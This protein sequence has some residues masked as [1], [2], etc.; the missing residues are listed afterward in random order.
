[1]HGA[2]GGIREFLASLAQAAG[3]DEPDA[4]ARQWHIL[5]KGSIV[6]AGEGDVDAALRSRE[7]GALLL[8]RHGVGARAGAAVA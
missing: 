5:M 3:I 2:P 7:L 4:F 6:A 8:E 1:M